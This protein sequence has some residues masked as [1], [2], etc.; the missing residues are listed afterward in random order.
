MKVA[1]IGAGPSGLVCCKTL[2]EN[3]SE[4]YPFD[5]VVLEQ[6]EDIGGTFRYRAYEVGPLLWSVGVLLSDS[7]TSRFPALT[8]RHTRVIQA[9]HV[10]LGL[11]ITSLTS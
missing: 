8:E 10:L 6:E 2:L 5:P 11:S 3:A 9:A 7:E 1:I 4:E